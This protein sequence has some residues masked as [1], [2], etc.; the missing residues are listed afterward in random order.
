ML[1]WVELVATLVRE[2][3][4]DVLLVVLAPGEAAMK[5]DECQ[6]LEGGLMLGKFKW[7]GGKKT[8]DEESPMTFNSV[9]LKL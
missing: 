2:G 8:S 7:G 4:L 9:S 6:W 3:I 1:L 5:G